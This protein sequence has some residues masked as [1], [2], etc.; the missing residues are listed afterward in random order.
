VKNKIINIS[1]MLI[2]MAILSPILV[3]FLIPPIYDTLT[4]KETFY[5]YTIQDT[6]VKTIVKKHNEFGTRTVVSGG[7]SR[8]HGRYGRGYSTI[9]TD[10]TVHNTYMFIY[11]DG[12]IEEVDKKLY[13]KKEEGDTIKELSIEYNTD[14]NKFNEF[15]GFKF[16]QV[17]ISSFISDFY[18]VRY[19]NNK[20]ID[21]IRN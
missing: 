7:I 11:N 14:E 19:L 21:T 17:Y 4:E 9:S 18:E 16:K 5:T 12:S 2:I 1:A 20:V 10:Y 13:D 8:G 3:G 6:L 15:N